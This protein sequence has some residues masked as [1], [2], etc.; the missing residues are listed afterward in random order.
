MMYRYIIVGTGVAGIS[1]AETIRQR[2]PFS[3]LMIISDDPDGYYSR[4]GIAY[5][6]NGLI[7]EKQLFPFLSADF[8]QLITSRIQARVTQ[9]LPEM[10][11]IVLAN[12]DQLAYDRLLLATGSRATMI[13][14]PGKELMGNVT[15]YTIEDVRHILKLVKH[16]TEAVVIGDG[17][18]GIEL[19]EG[20]AARNIRV[21]LFMLGD[22]LWPMVLDESESRLVERGL[23][24]HGIL[25]HP[26]TQLTEA[27]GRQGVLTGV[28]TKAG[29]TIPCQMLGIAIGVFAEIEL[30]KQ[31]GLSTNRGIL[32]NE[33]LETSS[34]DIFAAG[35]VAQIHDSR[36][37]TLF[38]ETLWATARS[39]GQ[40][41]GVNMTGQHIAYNRDTLL[42]VVCIGDIITATIGTFASSPLSLTSNDPHDWQAYRQKCDLEHINL[43]NR[44]RVLVGDRAIKGALVM[45]DQTLTQRLV[46]MTQMGIDLT[47]IRPILEAQPERGI[48]TLINFYKEEKRQSVSN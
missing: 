40:V 31:A 14:F 46:N 29:K 4:P 26:A 47:P 12:G 45:G 8:Q 28:V 7:P 30:A 16:C 11:Q 34:K 15:L 3:K 41:A 10:H 33:F 43:V 9:I 22:R 5:Y 27:V 13:N 44:V 39:Q 6:L 17:I 42:N 19:A 36:N 2:D 32:V 21:H 35:N 20:L 37:D 1:A 23:R 24:H 38:M 25:L 48:K 18:I